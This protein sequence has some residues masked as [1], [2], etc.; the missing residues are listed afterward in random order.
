MLHPG[1]ENGYVCID[2]FV[3]DSLVDGDTDNLS[4][5]I[6]Y[7]AGSN[8]CLEDSDGD[9]MDDE[10]EYLNACVDIVV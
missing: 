9:G 8:P 4:N 1:W 10:W 6:E 5:L 2:L 3:G 7:T